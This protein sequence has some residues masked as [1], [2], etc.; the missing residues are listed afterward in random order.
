MSEAEWLVSFDAQAMIAALRGKGSE[1]LWRLFAVACVRRIEHLLRD[2]RSR[3]ALEI[4]ER[5]ADGTATAEELSEARFHARAAA[6][7]GFR[8]EYLDEIR[9]DF[10]WDAEY[11]AVSAARGAADAALQCVEEDIGERFDAQVPC[12]R[13]GVAVSRLA[14]LDFRES[15][16]VETHRPGLVVLQ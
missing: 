2:A 8:A 3:K 4:A 10:R 11:E 12:H 13:S 14:S 16:P 1:R 5:F 15:F 7:D 6:D 9:A